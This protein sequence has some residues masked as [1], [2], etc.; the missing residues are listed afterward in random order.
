MPDNIFA[1][2]QKIVKEYWPNGKDNCT[3]Q[4]N[5]QSYNKHNSKFNNKNSGNDVDKN[6]NFNKDKRN[7][8][9]SHAKIPENSCF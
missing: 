3:C 5:S 6:N 9:A 2:A 1:M 8:K 7:E 4:S